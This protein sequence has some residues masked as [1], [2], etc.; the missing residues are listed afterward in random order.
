MA[1]KEEKPITMAEVSALAGDSEKERA[2]KKFIKSFNKMPVEKAKEIKEELKTLNLIK[3]KDAHIVKIVDL[4]PVD[5]SE[6]NKIIVD[7]SLDEGE[8]NKILEVIKKY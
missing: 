8:V 5:A 6:L 2:I 1:I 3:L 4:M 7:V